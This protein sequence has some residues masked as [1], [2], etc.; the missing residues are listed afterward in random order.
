VTWSDYE[1]TLAQAA[2][3]ISSMSATFQANSLNP[4]LVKDGAL[5]IGADQFSA[6]GNP[7]SFSALIALDVAYVYQ[8]G[9]LVMQF[10]H[11]GSDSSSSAF[12]D[13][14]NLTSGGYGG[15]FRAISA[16][17]FRASSGT[18]ASATIVEIAFTPPITQTITRAGNQFIINGAG[19]LASAT[20][21]ILTATNV[22]LPLVQWTPISSNQFSAGGGFS[23]TNLIQ[24]NVPGQYFRVVQP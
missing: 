15:S 7:N 2:N 8:G 24:L 12:L 22:V 3:S 20:Y 16:N 17:S 9:D 4:V 1:V 21:R 14:V 6:G 5:S 11:T 23:Y 19:G 13:A 10:T 18:T